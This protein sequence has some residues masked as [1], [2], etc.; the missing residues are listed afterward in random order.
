VA[1]TEPQGRAEAD[2]SLRTAQAAGMISTQADCSM[3]AAID[4]LEQRADQFGC[5]V[6][7]IA[8]AV[9]DRRLHFD[10]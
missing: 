4:L 7:D 2:R 1:Q 9:I 6:A 5:R 3:E 8:T 10:E